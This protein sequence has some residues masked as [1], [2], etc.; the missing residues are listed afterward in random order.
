MNNQIK[1]PGRH[2]GINHNVTFLVRD[3]NNMK[4][5]AIHRGHNAA[6][7]SMI[8]GIAHYLTGDGILNQ[9]WHLLSS[10]VPKY[11]S[12]GTMGLINQESDES[13]YPL[14]IGAVDGDELTRFED[15]M[16][17]VPGYGADG[18]DSSL[19]NNRE[20]MGLGPTFANR[21]DTSHTINCELI[22]NTFPRVQISYR[23]I[24]PEVEA[25]FPQTIDVIYS[26]MISVGA[27]AQFREEDKDYLFITEA[28]LWSRQDWTEG[29]ENGLLAG[30]RLAPSNRVNWGMTPDS[31]TQDAID[32]YI[33]KFGQPTEDRN[34]EE[35]VAEHNRNLLKQSIL[36]VN[37]NQ[38]VQVIWK[39]QIGAI[40]QLVDI[41][42]IYSDGNI[43]IE[44]KLYWEF[45]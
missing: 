31:I 43:D 40:E 45:F 19:N 9:G 12:L 33:E 2:F 4:I 25:E 37:S 11:I 5:R 1:I 8:A 44:T 38:V 13:G 42:N 21:S 39:I 23:E 14:G 7:N 41:D 15:Y 22:S 34:I 6:T 16:M 32:D 30:Y 28:G 29:G 36:R 24:V 35:I 18:Y 27:L 26:A 10:Y 17:Q 3:A 20:Y